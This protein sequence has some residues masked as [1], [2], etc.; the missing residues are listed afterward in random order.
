MKN[1]ISDEKNYNIEQMFKIFKSLKSDQLCIHI[2]ASSGSF[3]DTAFKN[4]VKPD[5]LYFLERQSI[6]SCER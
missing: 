4:I 6:V 5:H 1:P 2:K 3:S